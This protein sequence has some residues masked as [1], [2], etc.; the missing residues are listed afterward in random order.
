MVNGEVIEALTELARARSDQEVHSAVFRARAALGAKHAEFSPLLKTLS[1]R[2]RE[3][4]QLKQLA[5]TDELTGVANRRTFRDAVT[6]ALASSQRT[7]ASV[8]LLLL[9]LDG[10][11]ALNDTFGHRVGDAAIC[12]LAEACRATLR[13]TDLVARLGGDEFG[14]LL[15][16]A[17]L[18]GARC[19]VDRLRGCIEARQVSG[20]PLRVSI[21]YAT[22]TPNHRLTDCELRSQADAALY[23]DKRA[24]QRRLAA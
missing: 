21:G 19:L 14:V 2:A 8:S 12:A 9:D 1:A 10:L 24:R 17:G 4:E 3:I 5:G 16:D 18:D 23:Q 6:R 20:I 22:S 15:M 7:K 13:S 11:K